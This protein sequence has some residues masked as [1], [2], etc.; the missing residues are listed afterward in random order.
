MKFLRSVLVVG[1]GSAGLTCAAFLR[2]AGVAVEVSE[3]SL[4]TGVGAALG[5]SSNALL[6]LREI[7]ALDRVEH[8]GM[9]RQFVE[10]GEHQMRLVAQHL[11]DL[12]PCAL[13]RL[14]PA[15]VTG[16]GHRRK[17]PDRKQTA[18]LVVVANLGLR[19]LH[20]RSPA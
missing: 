5:L 19:K 14:E 17:H 16:R 8:R 18:L 3:I 7:G 20:D 13:D 1:G 6:P 15:P 10:E 9:A 12:G 11:F 4:K 2:K